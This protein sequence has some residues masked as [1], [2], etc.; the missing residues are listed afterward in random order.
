MSNYYFS[1]VRHIVHHVTNLGEWLEAVIIEFHNIHG[2]LR[3]NTLCFK[4]YEEMR[5]KQKH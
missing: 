2:L 1:R 4:L 3:G 5:G